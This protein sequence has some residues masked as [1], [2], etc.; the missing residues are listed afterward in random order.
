MHAGHLKIMDALK[1]K[2]AQIK[3]QSVVVTL[4]P[5]PRTVLMP[6]KEIKLLNTLEEKQEL[7]EKAGIDHFVVIPFDVNLSK[8][9]AH[10]F[11]K[12]I[13]LEKIGMASLVVGYDNHFGHNKE[14]DFEAISKISSEYGFDVLRLEA[15][16]DNSERVSSTAIRV[17]LEFGDVEEASRLLGYY[18]K[19]TGEVVKGKMLGQSIGFP[20]ANIE[21]PSY[22]MVPRVGVYAVNVNVDDHVFCGMLNIGFRPTVEKLAL[23]KTIEVHLIDFEGDLYGKKITL[24]FVKRLRDEMKF[25]NL[26]ELINQL[27]KDKKESLKILKE[28][29]K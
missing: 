6:G 7:V 29:N 1:E 15:H 5:H 21:P 11:I 9:S 28:I 4:W 19:L 25:N 8:L 10:D 27:N 24:N 26:E 16:F 17:L 22:K 2:A 23:Y 20:T 14:G 12:N 18:Y 3:G 13:L